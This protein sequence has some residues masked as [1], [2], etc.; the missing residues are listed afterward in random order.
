MARVF[1]GFFIAFLLLILGIWLKFGGGNQ[2]ADLNTAPA[3]D[4]SALESVFSYAEPIGDLAVSENLSLYF[5]VHPAARTEGNQ[6]LR[7][8]DGIALPFPDRQS[9][10]SLFESVSSI[11]IDKQDRL[12]A[13]DHGQ[14][15]FSEPKL[16]AFDAK[17]GETLFRHDF[18]S[19]EAPRG[20]MLQDVSVSDDGTTVF[21][22]DTS[23]WRESPALIIVT[24]SDSKVTRVLLDHPAI[25]SQQW[26]LESAVGNL[27]YYGGLISIK[28]GLD[29][30]QVSPDG[31]WLYLA[32]MSHDSLFRMS[33]DDLGNAPLKPERYSDKPL[34]DALAVA[35]SGRVFIADAEHGAIMQ[36]DSRRRLTTLIQST[37]LRWPSA[38]TLSPD[39]WLYIGDSALPQVAL[40]TQDIKDAAAPFHIYRIRP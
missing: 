6:L 26:Q 12:W 7:I 14:F 37:A 17:T 1:L 10:Q 18:T 34:S 36:V 3:H 15:G 8:E 27:T 30:L 23:V 5:S 32:A 39:S 16:L 25:V 20:S 9:Q 13:V 4:A 38:M 29:A 35:A 31:R 11:S 40:Q 22:A 24:L 2:F 19:D 28:P 33:L 21:V